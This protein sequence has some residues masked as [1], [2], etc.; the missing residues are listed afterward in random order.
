MYSIDILK[1][2]AMIIYNRIF[3]M[4]LKYGQTKRLCINDV[5]F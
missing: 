4:N 1:N 5:M 3:W 2:S